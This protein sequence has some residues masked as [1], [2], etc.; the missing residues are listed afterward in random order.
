MRRMR[1][2]CWVRIHA[3][4]HTLTHIHS[5][6]GILIAFPRQQWFGTRASLLRYTYF[7][8]LIDVSTCT[9]T[10]LKTEA[11]CTYVPTRLYGVIN[12]KT[13]L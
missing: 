13:L 2:A 8:C 7:A 6:K 11:I 9:Y 12:H 1:F 5:E 10:G 4:K 3:R